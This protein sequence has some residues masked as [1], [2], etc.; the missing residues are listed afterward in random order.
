MSFTLLSQLVLV[1]HRS[2]RSHYR[3]HKKTGLQSWSPASYVVST[4]ALRYEAQRRAFAS[5]ILDNL[6]SDPDIFM[7][8][9]I[10][11]SEKDPMFISCILR[12]AMA[13]GDRY[14]QSFCQ[15]LVSLTDSDI[16]ALC[17][18][19]KHPMITTLLSCATDGH[20]AFLLALLPRLS[21]LNPLTAAE[22]HVALMDDGA[23]CGYDYRFQTQDDAIAWAKTP[24]AGK[25]YA[26]LR[27][28]MAQLSIDKALVEKR[29]DSIT[30]L[31]RVMQDLMVT[32]D[33]HDD[34][35]TMK[36]NLQSLDVKIWRKLIVEAYQNES[37]E[38][39]LVMLTQRVL[40]GHRDLY[41]LLPA[42]KIREIKDGHMFIDAI[43]QADFQ[44]D[45]AHDDEIHLA[46]HPETGTY[47]A[48]LVQLFPIMRSVFHSLETAY[49]EELWAYWQP[50]FA[51]YISDQLEC[52]NHNF[53]LFERWGWHRLLDRNCYNVVQAEALIF[54][55]C[56]ALLAPSSTI[57]SL[58]YRLGGRRLGDG[59][60]V[61]NHPV[62]LTSVIDAELL[63]KLLTLWLFLD[64]S[65]PKCLDSQLFEL[66]QEGKSDAE[67]LIEA[68]DIFHK[69]RQVQQQL[70]VEEG[71]YPCV[72]PD[73]FAD[74]LTSNQLRFLRASN[75]AET[76]YL[77]IPTEFYDYAQK[78]IY[79]LLRQLAC[80]MN[81]NIW[82]N[83]IDLPYDQLLH[84]HWESFK[85]AVM[86]IDDPAPTV[87]P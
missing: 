3:Y 73:A 18:I 68:C 71:D 27:E 19:K 62:L 42:E 10:S 20:D 39:L 34:W 69:I 55:A 44:E 54:F 64:S 47:H 8:I 61:T 24:L 46:M 37:S 83:Q 28:K 49:Y 12:A 86:A 50:V 65:S 25:P 9:A 21:A 31:R 17:R 6:I 87:S 72:L 84:H 60:F 77:S 23:A 38:C 48:G 51:D 43:D 2:H 76:G 40:A 74:I 36:S 80:M 22:I 53:E 67:R 58:Y 16:L 82:S 32:S 26:C 52:S 45:M 41:A 13:C 81:N 1:F 57:N 33:L 59:A 66:T 78:E 11:R 29:P 63:V 4:C 5:L 30:L 85:Q 56:D 15:L 14:V 70:P 75:V 35:H 79:N 7:H